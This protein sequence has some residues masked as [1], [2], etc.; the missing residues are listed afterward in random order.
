MH[1]KSKTVS[2]KNDRSPPRRH[3]GENDPELA[4]APEDNNCND[5]K[6][7]V[8]SKEDVKKYLLILTG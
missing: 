8:C 6:H 3:S 1:R 7:T 2:H 4:A 5:S